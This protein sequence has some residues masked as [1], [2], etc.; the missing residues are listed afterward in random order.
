MNTSQREQ[1]RLSCLRYCAAAQTMGISTHLLLAS[2]RSEG[3][4]ELK[5]E[6]LREELRYLEEKGLLQ[7]KLKLI[8]PENQIWQ[9]T[10]A[11]RDFL[12][13]NGIS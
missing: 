3:R 1:V 5:L 6:P 7:R 9:I 4:R 13:E 10:A 2:L 8:S 11:G 12:A